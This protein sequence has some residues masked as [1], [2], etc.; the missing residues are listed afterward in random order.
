MPVAYYE[1]NTSPWLYNPQAVT[2]MPDEDKKVLRS[3]HV[4]L[5]ENIGDPICICDHLYQHKIFDG[6]DMEEV[7]NMTKRRDRNAFLLRSIQTRGNILDL[8][9]D[10][11][12]GQRENQEAAAILLNKR[13]HGAD[14]NNDDK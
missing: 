3:C 7:E 2:A 11:M 4:S 8:V 1:A 9:I 5:L 14:Q 12:R 6:E 13:R 10:I